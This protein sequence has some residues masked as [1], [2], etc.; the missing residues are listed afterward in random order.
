MEQTVAPTC[1][2]RTFIQ[3]T[4]SCYNF[5]VLPF[6]F[7]FTNGLAPGFMNTPLDGSLAKQLAPLGA[8]PKTDL[9]T[10]KKGPLKLAQN[11]TQSNPPI[12]SKKFL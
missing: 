4:K 3:G 6:C 8:L 2:A 12:L 11:R 9:I 7:F 10:A 5:G 1:P